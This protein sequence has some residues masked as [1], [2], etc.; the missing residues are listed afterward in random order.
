[1]THFVIPY[2][3]PENPVFGWELMFCLRGIEKY[4]R[5][6]YDITIIGDCPAWVDQSKLTF[7]SNEHSFRKLESPNAKIND[8]Y[9]IAAEFYQDFVVIHDDM[10]MVNECSFNDFKTPKYIE[11]NL[12]YTFSDE[13]GKAL[14]KFQR[15]IRRA[16]KFLK[17]NQLP[18]TKNFIAHYPFFVESDKL[19]EVHNK[20]DLTLGYPFENIFY[21]FLREKG[22]FIKSY[23]SGHYTVK[24]NDINSKAK[25]LNHD[26]LGFICQPWIINLLYKLFPNQS[27][28]EKPR[29]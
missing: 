20:V 28:Y 29:N 15:N 27:K 4:F 25:I 2:K 21:N 18:Y 10:Y 9:L 3:I 8:Q 5:D 6:D 7:I 1:M 19:K 24:D 16:W 23:K 22:E 17:D 26:E 11:N 12:Y 14:S 13:E